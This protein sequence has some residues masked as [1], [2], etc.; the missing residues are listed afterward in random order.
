MNNPVVLINPSPG[1]ASRGVNEANVWPPMGLCSIGAALRERGVGA[2][3]ID[4]NL[5]RLLPEEVVDRVPAQALL[6]GIS[7]NSFTYDSARRI[8]S[9]LRELRPET[10]IILGGPLP[11]A[12][13]ELVLGEFAC[14]GLIRGEG[15]YGMARL[16]ENALAGA[17]LFDEGVA[18][19]AWRDPEGNVRENPPERIL[20]LDSLPF[21]ALD[22]APPLS[23]YKSRSRK[24]PIAPLITSRGCAHA[25]SFC[26]KDIFKR[27][28]SF[29]SPENVL[30]EIDH[31][32]TT[33]G[34]RQIDILDDNFAQKKTRM[35]AILQGLAERGY[36]LAVNLNAG[37][38]TEGLTEEDFILMR[39]AGVFKVAFGIESADP[40]VLAMCDKR[41]KLETVERCIGWARKM[42]FVVYGFFIIGLPGEDEAAF[43]KTL[44]F[45]RRTDLDVANFC[46]AAPF[47]GTELYRQVEK[48]GRFLVDTRKDLNEGFYA[49]KVFFEYG[50][51]RAEDILRRYRTAYRE[52]YS[53]RRQLRNLTTLRSFSELAWYVQTGVGVLKGLLSR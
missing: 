40:G 2:E 11:S 1:C 10:A 47:V 31:L 32:V 52:F 48:G 45:A 17:P 4:A 23:R 8:C 18:G 46:L 43:R 37:I 6:A 19:A 9:L 7:V 5:L 14:D 44:E 29:R 41:L 35:R 51:Q 24:R 53:L 50:G 30:A 34:V 15:E 21:P 33:R 28:V 36:D 13:A 16:A 26:S 39:R 49:G 27:R 42:G 38:R 25:C 3:L 22:L 20:D 12:N